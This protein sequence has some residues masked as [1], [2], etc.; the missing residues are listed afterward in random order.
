MNNIIQEG[1]DA[2]LFNPLDPEGVDLGGRFA[3][4]V[5]DDLNLDL[6]EELERLAQAEEG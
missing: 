5:P 2:R 3:F 4:G 1:G 6:I